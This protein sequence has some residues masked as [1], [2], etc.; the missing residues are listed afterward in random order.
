MAYLLDGDL[1]AFTTVRA[2][3]LASR[4]WSGMTGGSTTAGSTPPGSTSP[5][6]MAPGSTG[7]PSPSGA[8]I[9]YASRSAFSLV[10]KGGGGIRKLPAMLDQGRAQIGDRIGRISDLIQR[11]KGLLDQTDDPEIQDA[12]R[13]RIQKFAGILAR[14]RGT[15][16]QMDQEAVKLAGGITQLQGV[17]RQVD[18]L[19]GD[20]TLGILPL[21]WGAGVGLTALGGWI[22]K[23]LAESNVAEKEA[24]NEARK[25]ELV[26]AG[27]I[28]K[29]SLTEGAAP[30]ISNAIKWGAILAGSVIAWKVFKE[31]RK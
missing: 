29:E 22:W 25:L 14:I 12:I 4:I 19:A 1:G 9:P 17:S 28:P 21:V 13:K 24:E 26:A 2:G 3:S 27:Q 10:G 31:L 16:A 15:R 20:G 18:G 11:M 23:S 7:G 8:G 6:G 30:Q 5:G